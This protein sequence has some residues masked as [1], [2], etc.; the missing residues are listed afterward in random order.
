MRTPVEYESQRAFILRRKHCAEALCAG[1][2]RSCAPSVN[3]CAR[4]LCAKGLCA[5]AIRVVRFK[6]HKGFCLCVSAFIGPHKHFRLCRF[7]FD[8]FFPL[9]IVLKSGS[10]RGEYRG[11][12]GGAPHVTP[13]LQ[14]PDFCIG[15]VR[16][17]FLKMYLQVFPCKKNLHKNLNRTIKNHTKNT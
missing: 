5:N 1:L 11:R 13:A 15:F 7:L 12:R 4:G 16:M 3:A 9:D 17:N 10:Q 6:R 8:T 14:D 2:V